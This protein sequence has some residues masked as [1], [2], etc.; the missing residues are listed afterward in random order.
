MNI[1]DA[2]NAAVK[3]AMLA[4]DKQS[5]L[6][7]RAMT[8]AFKQIEIDKQIEITDEVALAELVRQVKM[9]QDAAAQF[10]AADRA[11]LAEKEEAEIIVIQRF[12]PEQLDEAAMEA[13]IEAVLSS[14]GLPLEKASMGAFMAKLKEVLHGRA[15]MAKVSQ[16]LRTR[17]Q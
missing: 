3:E 16:Y 11:E 1:R 13:E 4:K 7:L 2:V 10:R 8:A 15:D 17:L 6:T 12:L 14:L 9:R 5:L